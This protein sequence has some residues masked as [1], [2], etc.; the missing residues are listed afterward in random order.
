[1]Y[2]SK[3]SYI[4]GFHGLDE[5]IGRSVLNGEIELRHSNNS[6]DWL[7]NGVYFWENSYERARQY[8]I[9]DSRRPNTKIKK[10][11]VIGAIIDL[12]NCLDLLDKK[13]LDFL[14]FAYNEMVLTLNENG[15]E[16]PTN[17]TFGMNDFDFKKRELDCAV[18]RY[19]VALGQAENNKFDSVRAAFWEGKELYPN[20]GFKT[21]NHIQLSVINLNCKKGIFLPRQ[22]IDQ[23]Q[24]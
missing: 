14:L 6:Y 18:V 10:P 12:G 15:N 16:L 23:D 21:H 3:P 5:D 20:A 11:F 1:L 24:T 17:S 22:K 9:Q 4:F 8:A 19:A 7:G 2:S 13:W